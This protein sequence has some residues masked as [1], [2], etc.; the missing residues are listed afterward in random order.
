MFNHLKIS[1]INVNNSLIKCSLFYVYLFRRTIIQ[2]IPRKQAKLLIFWKCADI[3]NPSQKVYSL[4]GLLGSI[5]IYQKRHISHFAKS[6]RSWRKKEEKCRNG[7]IETLVRTG[8]AERIALS[9]LVIS[10]DMM[11]SG[12][13]LAT[14]FLISNP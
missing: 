5:Y 10:Y 13:N 4:L 1:R 7:I 11:N 12:E 14:I 2:T 9:I 6:H 3:F 8:R